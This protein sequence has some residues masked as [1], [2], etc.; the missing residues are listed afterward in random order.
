[1]PVSMSYIKTKLT[2]SSLICV[3]N[4][5]LGAFSDL[6][7]SSTSLFGF[8]GEAAL[9]PLLLEREEASSRSVADVMTLRNETRALL[10][11][12]LALLGSFLLPSAFCLPSSP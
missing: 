8:P 5:A 4:L 7:R 2:W 11:L 10:V 9:D 1:M 6:P 12:L 3:P